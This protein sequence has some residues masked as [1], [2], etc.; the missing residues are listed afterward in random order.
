MARRGLN[1]PI[2][3]EGVQ[4]VG[5]F[6]ASMCSPGEN[7]GPLGELVPV[8]NTIAADWV[9]IRYYA[10]D[11]DGGSDTAAGFSDVSMPAAGVVALKTIEEM[12]TRLPKL[13]QGQRAV[14]AIKARAGGANYLKKDGVT[15]DRLNLNGIYGYFHL[16]VRGTGDVPT[17][18]AVAFANDTADKIALG[19]RIVAGTNAA[20]YNPVAPISVSTFDVQLS[21]GG[22]PALAVEP[23]LIGKRI[24]FD[25]ATTTVALR[26]AAAM[27]HANDTDT[28]TVADDLPAV[29]VTTDVFYIE[30]P[31]VAVEQLAVTSTTPN[32]Q[33]EAPS[34][35]LQGIQLA[36]IRCTGT[37][38][39]AGGFIIGPNLCLLSFID[40]ASTSFTAFSV[41]NFQDVR[42]QRSYVDEAGTTII[43]GVGCRAPGGINA[44]RGQ[45]MTVAS[46]ALVGPGGIGRVQ[47]LN[48]SQ[49]TIGAGCYF[50][51]G[52]LLQ[53]VGNGANSIGA[54][55]ATL[56]GKGPSTTVR[57]LRIL[58]PAGSPSTGLNVSHG[59]A[60][61][62][63]VDITGMGA[64]SAILLRGIN[65][66]S[67][68]QDAVGSTGNTGAGVDLTFS[69]DGNFVMGNVAV[70]TL[71]GGAGQDVVGVGGVRY[72]H[73]DY[74]LTDLR[75]DGGNHVQGAAGTIMGTAVVATNDA[76][77]DIGQYK[78]V[79]PTASGLVQAAIASAA[80]TAIGVGVTQSPMTAAGSQRAMLAN[81][82]GTWI[83]FDAAPTAG[84]I[85]Y[86]STATAGN[87]QDT[88]P[89]TAGTNQKLRLGR[90]LRVSGTLGFVGWHPESL[91][92][93][94]D[95]LA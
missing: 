8:R 48:I 94:A 91:A 45:F 36:G 26:N 65:G 71:T 41:V 32:S 9:G 11:Y 22:A 15:L 79:R 90:V 76:V 93:L 46:S 59:E 1:K 92:V 85:A 3:A 52:V 60:T 69:K 2:V 64:S 53:G 4:I 50:F 37:G 83:Q 6:G 49:H 16:L 78:I 62:W 10:V 77:A 20:G 23:A 88:V 54:V 40:S 84:N 7:N 35:A 21:G 61:I 75:D 27:I 89:A 95:G 24:R 42:F 29:P 43:T 30:E 5:G 34:F 82:G 14:V 39:G 63:G 31:G 12:L 68:I 13:G 86:L 44:S 80:A 25:S 73:A 87:A 81:G 33:G 55:F 28:I 17:A 72:V 19:A 66:A 70:N 18:G 57:R 56:I 38:A 74:A 51:I 67:S 58:A 47:S